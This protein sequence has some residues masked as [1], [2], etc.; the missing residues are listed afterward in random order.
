M[1]NILPMLLFLRLCQVVLRMH[2]LCACLS[3]C[4]LNRLPS[5]LSAIY[6]PCCLPACLASCPPVCLPVLLSPENRCQS[7]AGFPGGTEAES[8]TRA[9]TAEVT[10][11]CLRHGMS[12][13]TDETISL[14]SVCVCEHVLVRNRGHATQGR[15]SRLQVEAGEVSEGWTPPDSSLPRSITTRLTLCHVNSNHPPLLHGLCSSLSPRQI[16]RPCWQFAT[17][18]PKSLPML[19]VVHRATERAFSPIDGSYSRNKLL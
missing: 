17:M 16:L 3:A 7:G 9:L 13:S 6:L 14:R 1:H 12:S 8:L 18:R 15:R 10:T 11:D 19:L 2:S 4:L 5:C